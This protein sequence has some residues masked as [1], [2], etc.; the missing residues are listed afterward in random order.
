MAG[1]G[2]IAAAAL[3]AFFVGLLALKWLFSAL[4]KDRFHWFAYYCWLVALSVLVL[5]K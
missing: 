1:F 4:D 3:L 5:V 2:A